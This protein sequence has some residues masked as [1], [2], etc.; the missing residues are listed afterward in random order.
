MLRDGA[1]YVTRPSFYVLLA[2]DEN[3]SCDQDVTDADRILFFHCGKIY[4]MPWKLPNDVLHCVCDAHAYAHL[5]FQLS[6][7]WDSFDVRA[8]FSYPGPSQKCEPFYLT[9]DF[10]YCGTSSSIHYS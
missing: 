10:A 3:P 9:P 4:A 8:R 7:P 2:S 6:H 1:S 5:F